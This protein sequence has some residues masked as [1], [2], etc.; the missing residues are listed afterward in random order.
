MQLCVGSTAFH[1]FQRH[2]HWI[3]CFKQSYDKGSL[4][5]LFVELKPLFHILVG[6]QCIF[7]EMRP[8]N[9]NTSSYGL[10][11]AIYAIICWHLTWKSIMDRLYWI[12]QF[13]Y[14][15]AK[16]FFGLFTRNIFPGSMLFKNAI[17][18]LTLP[19]EKFGILL[20]CNTYVFL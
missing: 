18:L 2:S 20:I 6:Q 8:Y 4:N 16:R 5:M 3:R 11:W 15:P 12:G 17:A 13:V 19:R 7:L 14:C 1:H 10:N 9:S